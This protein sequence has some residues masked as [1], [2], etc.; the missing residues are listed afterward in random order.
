[1]SALEVCSLWKLCW[2]TR[3]SKQGLQSLSL[4]DTSCSPVLL[5]S[6]E[7]VVVLEVSFR[8]EWLF[9]P[10]YSDMILYVNNMK[11]IFIIVGLVSLSSLSLIWA[12]LL[13]SKQWGKKW[14]QRCF[15]ILQQKTIQRIWRCIWLSK[16]QIHKI[17]CHGWHTLWV[18]V[19]KCFFS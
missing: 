1:M 12:Q 19:D 7:R 15:E 5:W 4:S 18:H 14:C 10:P 11:A 13:A 6:T 3:D 8:G 2:V 16:C 9:F 17:A